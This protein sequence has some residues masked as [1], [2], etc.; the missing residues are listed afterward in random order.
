M[1]LERELSC[2]KWFKESVG[3]I[4]SGGSQSVAMVTGVSFRP[5]LIQVRSANGVTRT[6]V[7]VG[8]GLSGIHERP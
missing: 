2:P 8:I 3:G 4:H 1:T 6:G 5:S 7:R